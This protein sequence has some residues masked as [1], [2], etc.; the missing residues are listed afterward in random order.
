MTPQLCVWAKPPCED[1]K[2]VACENKFTAEHR[3]NRPKLGVGCVITCRRALI[4]TDLNLVDNADD[5]LARVPIR[6][7][8]DHQQLG[9]GSFQ[10]GFFVEF[11][12]RCVEGVLSLV[13]KTAGKRPRPFHRRVFSLNQKDAIV[14]AH[15]C[16]SGQGRIEPTV[17]F[18]A[19]GHVTHRSVVRVPD[20]CGWL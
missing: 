3:L 20:T 12:N 11:A 2:V 8:H 19:R 10:A 9:V 5:M 1:F 6:V 17:A 13:N 4:F 16:V 7:A 18:V 14:A 15:G